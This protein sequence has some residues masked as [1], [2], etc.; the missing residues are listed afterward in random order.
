MMRDMTEGPGQQPPQDPRDGA[1]DGG[2]EVLEGLVIPSRRQPRHAGQSDPRNDFAVPQN[3]SGEQ[4]AAGARDAG[5]SAPAGGPAWTP[6][7]PG[8]DAGLST[9]A[10][11]QAWAPQGGAG[12]QD[13]G[14][15]LP[16]AGQAWAPQGSPAPQL[17]A[18]HAQAPQAQAQPQ[19][20]VQGQG[21]PPQQ[22]YGQ[23]A[24]GV[25]PQQ[26]AQGLGAPGPQGG[27]HAGP[28]AGQGGPW[29]APQGGAQP[30]GGPGYGAGAPQAAA[31]GP[32]PPSGPGGPTGPTPPDG[33]TSSGLPQRPLS[34][35]R[36]AGFGTPGGPQQQPGQGA[37]GAGA[38]Q[39]GRRGAGPGAAVPP[40]GPGAGGSGGGPRR[41][42]Q[43]AGPSAATPDWN[44]LAAEQEASGRRRRKVT[45]LTGGIV[46]VA[47]IAGGVA[48]AVV[49]SGK[50][51]DS[52][53]DKPSASSGTS[54]SQASLPPSPSF[55]SVAPPPPANPLDYLSSAAKDKAPLTPGSLFPGKQFLMGGKA[56]V[57]T[58]A[59]STTSCATGAR[60]AVAQALTANGCRKLIRATYTN[61]GVAVTVGVA[62]F[63]DTAHA[64][65]LKRV[66]EY[67]MPLNGGGVHDFCHAVAC[68]MTSNSVGRYAY[69]AIA[70]LKDGKTITTTD[71][72]A[73][74]GANDASNFAFQRIIQRGRD[75][76]A[77]DPSR[78]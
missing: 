25:P 6:Q 38:P 39:T 55:S 75:A 70:G 71:K 36:P 59:T 2:R 43:A 17:P 62:V 53:I 19:Q 11:G 35:G 73:L 66:A 28:A 60:A 32:T 15:Q 74:T 56:Y 67:L 69:F 5:Q 78:N 3:A 34:G 14:H 23:G 57:K 10:A 41:G 37:G 4:S 7:A 42:P 22:A 21:V 33:P 9:P 50:S 46:A 72:V 1:S 45:M 47:V 27:Q 13:A 65:K 51:S 26:P 20:P 12:G 76:A 52:A 29:A 18:Q 40:R 16:G 63:D 24:Q 30:A 64:D 58:A 54:A 77:A 48:T 49:M 44:A 61:G 68:R 31:G 8:P